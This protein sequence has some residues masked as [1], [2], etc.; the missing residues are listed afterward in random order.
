MS[1]INQHRLRQRITYVNDTM[2]ATQ[3]TGK[4]LKEYV[5]E[6]MKAGELKDERA[7]NASD[8]ARDFGAGI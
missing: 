8:F 3:Y 1:S 2:A 5:K 4:S 7:G 6:L